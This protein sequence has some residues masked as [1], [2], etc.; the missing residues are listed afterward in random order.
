ME[1]KIKWT[2]QNRQFTRNFIS[3][4]RPRTKDPKRRGNDLPPQQKNLALQHIRNSLAN[5]PYLPDLI[6]E[7]TDWMTL[8]GD[9][10]NNRMGNRSEA[11]HRLEERPNIDPNKWWNLHFKDKVLSTLSSMFNSIPPT[12]AA[13]ERTWSIRAAVHTKTRNR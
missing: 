11:W 7:L 1:C 10:E 5:H 13:N 3:H 4:K 6:G 9:Y 2:S 12:S 8:S